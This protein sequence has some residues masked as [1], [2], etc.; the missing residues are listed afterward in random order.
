MSRTLLR[1]L[2]VVGINTT[3]RGL[4]LQAERHARDDGYRVLLRLG[5][6]SSVVVVDDDTHPSITATYLAIRTRR[7]A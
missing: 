5:A 4:R 1:R 3:R 2:R 7:F 6:R